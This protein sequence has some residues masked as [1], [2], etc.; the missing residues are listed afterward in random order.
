MRIWEYTL[1][2]LTG[3][4]GPHPDTAAPVV[5][6]P[7]M[8]ATVVPITDNPRYATALI[9]GGGSFA[10]QVLLEL[11]DGGWQCVGHYCD[12][13]ILLDERVRGKGLA[14][15]LML[16]CLEHRENRPVTTEF[17]ES[18]LRCF[19]RTHRLAV[20][21]AIKAGLPVPAAVLQEYGA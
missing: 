18:G 1:Q 19:K 6:Q 16:R 15:E 11:V 14:E 4:K 10:N 2:Q 5:A 21:R 8:D 20:A 13:T 3:G 7:F 17:T 12:D 9:K